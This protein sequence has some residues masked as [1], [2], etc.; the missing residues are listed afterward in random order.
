[1]K[2]TTLNNL[3]E[4]LSL[5]ATV[6]G[7]KAVAKKHRQDIDNYLLNINPSIFNTDTSLALL[8][9]GQLGT[10]ILGKEA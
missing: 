9:T 7:S 1:M 6:F 8:G 4:V 10:M 5:M 2:I 3:E